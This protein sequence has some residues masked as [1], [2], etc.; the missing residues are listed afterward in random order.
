MLW[1]GG[2]NFETPPPEFTR[3]GLFK[4]FPPTGALTLD[5]R[6]AFYYAYTLDSL[7]MIMRIP[8]VGSQYLMGFLDTD[9]HP[10]DGAKTY[11]VTL[12]PNI[13][14]RLLVVHRVRQP[15]ALDARHATALPACRQPELSVACRRAERRR[16]HDGLLRPE[17]TRRRQTQ[18][19]DSNPARQGL[20][21]DPAPLQPAGVILRQELA[22]ER[23][24]IGALS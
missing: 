2:A 16:L 8:D 22:P 14:A 17:T 6:T 18:Q 5:S 24:R 10:F 7:G 19:L 12:P 11:K 13:P 9:K 20:V 21:Y 23:D 1:E 15:V 4:P 3:E